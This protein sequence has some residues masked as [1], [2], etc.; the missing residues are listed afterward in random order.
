MD[1]LDAPPAS[2]PHTTTVVV[3]D[4]PTSVVMGERFRIKVGVKC[5]S[6]CSLAAGRFAID[7]HTGARVATGRLPGGLWPGTTGLY[8]AE[9]ELQAPA[10]QG[11]YTWSVRAPAG[12]VGVSHEEGSATFGVRVVTRPEHRVIVEAFDY[13]SQSPLAGARVMMHPYQAVTDARGVAELRVAKGT[14]RLFV[15]QARYMTFG[16]PVDVT[17]DLTTRAELSLEPVLERN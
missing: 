5:S 2:T 11:L 13:E 9:V 12:E 1:A 6:E 16:L 4:V 15:S 8:A 3:W 7:D 14:Y 10:E 17:G